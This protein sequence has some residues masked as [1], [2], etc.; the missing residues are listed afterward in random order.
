MR[1]D[2]PVLVYWVG[3]L[4]GW[5]RVILISLPASHQTYPFVHALLAG[6][7]P[8]LQQALLALSLQLLPSQ[9]HIRVLLG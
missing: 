8:L 2:W 5:L 7:V 9:Q 6:V 1:I 4:Y 3:W